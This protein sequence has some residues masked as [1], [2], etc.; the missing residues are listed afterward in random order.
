MSQMLFQGE[1]NHINEK[2]GTIQS[3]A[4]LPIW[5]LNMSIYKDMCASGG[6]F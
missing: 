6:E 2:Q 4:M 3:Q 5:R 1:K